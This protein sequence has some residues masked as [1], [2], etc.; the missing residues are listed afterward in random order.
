[1]KCGYIIYAYKYIEYSF[2]TIT[3]YSEV[4]QCMTNIITAN[5]KSL[6]SHQTHSLAG[7]SGHE[8]TTNCDIEGILSTAQELTFNYR[9][10]P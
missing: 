2:Y 6:N 8:T 7:G 1:M 10:I 9:P 3:E 4:T 5:R